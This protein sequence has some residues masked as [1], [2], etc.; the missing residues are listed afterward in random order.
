MC[1]YVSVKEKN[2]LKGLLSGEV[3]IQDYRPGFFFSGFNQPELPIMPSDNPSSVQA[4]QWGLI[5]GWTKSHEQA[6][7][8]RTKT[9]NARSETMFTT[10][11]YRQYASSNRCLIF[12]DGFFEWKHVGKDKIPHFIYMEDHRPFAFGGLYADWHIRGPEKTTT[13][14][15]SIVTTASNDLMTDIHNSKLR[16]PLILPEESWSVWLNPHATQQEVMNV[17][18]PY[19]KNDL[20]AHT[21]RKLNPRAFNDT[22]SVQDPVEWPMPLF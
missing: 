8:T 14:T 16:M 6:N 9:L 3:S 1:Y 5:P 10:P 13:R 21:I 18:M 20:Y 17:A 12:V 11:M 15:C 4:V 19:H 2:Q 7:E 22:P